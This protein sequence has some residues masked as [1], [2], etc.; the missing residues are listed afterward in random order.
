M[1]TPIIITAENFAV[2]ASKRFKNVDNRIKC[3]GLA[4]ILISVS[5]LIINRRIT[6]LEAEILNMK[7]QTEDKPASE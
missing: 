3:L 5:G 4:V 7:P 2:W 1:D 6:K